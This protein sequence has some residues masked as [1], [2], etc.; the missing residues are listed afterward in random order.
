MLGKIF[1][2]KCDHPMADV[3][4]AQALLNNLPKNDTLKSIMELT[5]WIESVASREDFR[6]ADQWSVL[7]LL[8]ETAQPYVKKLVCEYFTL[9]DM[10]AFQGNRLC[11]A[12]GNFSRQM[13]NAYCLM[14][15]R[16][17]KNDAVARLP[18]LVAR[19]VRLMGEQ[20][21]YMVVHY[22]THDETVWRNFAALYHHAEQQGYLDDTVNLYPTVTGTVRTE[23]GKLTAWYACGITSLSPRSMHLAELIFAKNS[24][25][26]AVSGDP[27]SQDFCS[28]D[29]SLSRPPVRILQDAKTSPGLRYV[30][31]VRMQAR[32]EAL[33]RILEKNILPEEMHL[34]CAYTAEWVME[35]AQYVVSHVATPPQRLAKRR[36]LKAKLS[37]VF[38]CENLLA[39]AAGREMEVMQMTLENASPGGF[40][41]E[42]SGKGADSVRIGHV[43][44]VK[45]A[46]GLGVSIVRR[47]SRDAEGK[48][49]AG[50]E[51]LTNR[52]IL[53]TL[54]SG[55]GGKQL[56]L[57]AENGLATMLMQADVFSMQRSLKVLFDGRKYLLMPVRLLESGLDYD[58]ASFRVIEQEEE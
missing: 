12:L 27:G 49:H 33:I 14:F 23:A 17:C 26:I 10:H 3:K 48:L 53:V 7:N 36:E 32:L 15:A 37:V 40:Y 39:C 38:G 28:F 5:D 6:L 30:S 8:D 2:R 25:A 54:Q 18:V 20:L 51:I 29:L 19:A 42:L 52:A 55:E 35:A 45:N 31:V 11:M 13:C 47:L 57:H 9:P 24:D 58:L 44:G 21:K 1:G 43:F 50:A 56:W 34:G 41:A 46:G 16:Y 4:S 22:Q